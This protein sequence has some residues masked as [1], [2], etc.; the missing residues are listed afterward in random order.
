MSSPVIVDLSGT[1]ALVT[2]S[3]RGIG[4]AVAENLLRSGCR[5]VVNGRTAE[6]V[7]TAIARLG[8]RADIV[9]AVADVSTARGCAHIVDTHPEVDIVVGN[10]AGF[11][12]KSFLDLDDDDWLREYQV[13]VLAAV[14][15]AKA[16][17]PKML[18]NNWGRIVLVASEAGLNIPGDM[19]H[20][21]VTKAAEIAFARGLAETT[22]GTGVT[23]NSVLPGPTASSDADRFLDDYAHENNV[24]RA[25]ADRH[26]TMS[27]RPTTLLQRLA[28]VDEVANMI[29]YACSKESSATNGAALR[30]EG[31][32]LRHPG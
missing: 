19:I 15:L 3:T 23:V 22:A 2:G 11:E 1:T 12:W 29:L 28:R 27:I 13:N 14:R 17:L 8:P 24:P 26:C 18:E 10:A 9:G 30:V 21:G 31:G 5:V 4:F 32:I 20:Y 25:D 6:S 7:D 16:Y